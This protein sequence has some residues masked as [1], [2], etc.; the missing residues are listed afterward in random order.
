MRWPRGSRPWRYTS[1]GCAA[2]SAAA[3]AGAAPRTPRLACSAHHRL[4]YDERLFAAAVTGTVAS[5]VYLRILRSPSL[6]ILRRSPVGAP[7]A[8][9]ALSGG[10]SL[11]PFLVPS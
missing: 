7:P 2:S 11:T 1:S 6:R 10:E 5:S 9:Q 3:P 4:G 8:W